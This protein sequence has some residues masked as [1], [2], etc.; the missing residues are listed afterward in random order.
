MI[1]EARTLL[2]N[3]D[4]RNNPGP[5]FPGE[6]F[7]PTEARIQTMPAYLDNLW[8]LFFGANPDRASVNYRLRELLPVLHS[9]ELSEFIYNLDSR[10]TYW[11]F[12]QNLFTNLI[13]GAVIA[14]LSGTTKNLFP[15][16]SA[17]QIVAGDQLYYKWRITVVNGTDVSV[18]KLADPLS[19]PPSPEVFNYTI[20]AGLS[21][22]MSLPGSS[23]FFRFEDGVGS[24][25]E[26][27]WMARPERGLGEIME[28][29]AGIS[30]ELANRLFS[31]EE[32][33]KTFRNLWLMHPYRPY[34]MGGV[35]LALIYRLHELRG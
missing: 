23:E 8:H 33:Y 17:G 3:M 31:T 20:T 13:A 4:G 26:M 21:S 11:P 27:T 12:A 10:V 16:V 9:T 34:R 2:L 32:P 30:Q 1:N 7:V 6:E 15:L 24:Q 29:A 25:W 19:L 5:N 14:P 18:Q 22:L 35:L 28:A